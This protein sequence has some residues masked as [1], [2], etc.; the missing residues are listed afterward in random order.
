M[1]METIV[2][3]DLRRE[4]RFCIA[5]ECNGL[6]VPALASEF[7]VLTD[8]ERRR[9][10]EIVADEAAGRIRSSPAS[11]RR[12]RR[13]RPPSRAMPRQPARPR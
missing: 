1:P 10:V 3:A 12:A 8:D 4:V 7:M 2:E 9:V 6:V 13:G 5:A 11:L